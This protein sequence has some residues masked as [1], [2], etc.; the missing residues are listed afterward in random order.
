MLRSSATI[1]KILYGLLFALA[2]PVLLIAWASVTEKSVRLPAFKL[3]AAGT[4][5][6]L[7]GTVIMLA[8]IA[9]LAVYG[10]GL[11]MNAYPP[12]RY[13]TQ[14][15]YKLT[16]HPIYTG[17]SILCIGTAIATGSASGLWLVSPVVVLGCVALV[18]GFEN[19]DLRKRFD[20]PQAQPWLHLPMREQ[21]PPTIPDRVS[22]YLLVFL[23]WVILY[24]AVRLIGIPADAFV[25]FF[26]VETRL[27]VYEWTELIYASTYAFVLLV[28]LIAKSKADLRDFSIA[29]FIATGLIILLFLVVPFIAPPR[30][31]LPRGLLGNLLAWERAHDTPAAAFP[32][33]HVVWALLAARVYAARMPAWRVAWWGWALLISISCVTT[34]MHAIVDVLAGFIVFVL[35]MRL[36]VVWQE[37]RR[38]TE[39]IA[40]SWREWRI[41]RVR[42]INHGLYAA[43]GVF[44]GLS[45]VG[46]LVG[47][48]YT[49]SIMII[50][51]CSLVTSAL[52]A[53]LVEAS[54]SLL[55]PYGWYGGLLGAIIGAFVVMPFGNSPWVLLSA[56]SIAAPWIQSF[57]RLRC[58]VQGCCH[59]G[60]ALPAIGIRYTHP[61]S[62]V[63]RL[64]S[65]AGVPVHPTPLYSI[66]SNLVIA[67]VMTRF[68]LVHADFSLIV[69]VFLILNGLARF[70]EESYRGEPQTPIKA[71]LRS[72]QWL[73]IGSVIAGVFATM[74]RNTGH[75]SA[76]SLNWQSLIAATGFSMVV[77][78]ALGVDF[79]NSNK[80]FARLA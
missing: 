30:P 17:F 67:I 7:G 2:L 21:A 60:A 61:R 40:N 46:T 59:G 70:V 74:V 57:G 56:F 44:V 76:L 9:A 12:A 10:K 15:I 11:P 8:G 69:G 51:S 5:L 52:W 6:A 18:Q 75:P 36:S 32:S 64:T 71:G 29:S 3:P 34:G 62:R 65:L 48:R 28:P 24:E 66:L 14:G 23:P 54:P 45:I 73:A 25:A 13:V 68:W 33:F 1:G 63:S 16:A 80:R 26:R 4:T 47:P 20:H 35:V 55:R 43:I 31:F 49:A 77:W 41:G 42:I 37:V 39:R 58:L 72:Y 78:F 38:L 19:H 79:P 22:V 50:A 27:P 53:Q